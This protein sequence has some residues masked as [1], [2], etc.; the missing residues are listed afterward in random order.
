MNQQS[1]RSSSVVDRRSFMACLTGLGFGATALPTYLWAQAQQEGTITADLLD[2]AEAVMGLE[3]T[4]DERELMLQGLNR[5]LAA[6]ETLR[7]V[8]IPNSVPPA[9]M[10]DPVLPG[11]PFPPQ[12]TT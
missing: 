7:S 11:P 6:Y 10:F 5:N 1:P 8:T 3:F 4:D 9:V 2:D 12:S